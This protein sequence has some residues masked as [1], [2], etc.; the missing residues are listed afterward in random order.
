MG[1]TGTI[2]HDTTLGALLSTFGDER[3]VIPGGLPQYTAS[4]A[5]ELWMTKVVL[6]WGFIYY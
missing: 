1:K 3:K 4:V 2:K 5:I 6:G